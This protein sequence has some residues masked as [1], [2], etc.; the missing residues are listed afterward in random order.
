MRSTIH[1]LMQYKEGIREVRNTNF[2]F[3]YNQNLFSSANKGIVRIIKAE[4]SAVF[5][6][7]ATK[8]QSAIERNDSRDLF[9][10]NRLP[11]KPRG[12]Q[13]NTLTTT[14]GE[15][16]SA[17]NS[18]AKIW[19]SFFSQK[20]ARHITTFK[21]PLGESASTNALFRREVAGSED[22]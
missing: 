22:Y 4:L 6:E 15:V 12:K 3:S 9:F 16:A 1:I 8:M 14:N 7:R 20:L 17:A 18:V 21:Q 19:Q 11:S 2:T 10:Y 13:V 5:T